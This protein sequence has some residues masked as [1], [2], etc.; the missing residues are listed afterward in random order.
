LKKSSLITV[1]SFAAASNFNPFLV[2][3]MVGISIVFSTAVPDD[4]HPPCV[5]KPSILLFSSSILFIGG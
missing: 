2:S 1:N 4:P 5:F 3:G